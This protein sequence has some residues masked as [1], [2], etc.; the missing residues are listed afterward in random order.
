MTKEDG[1]ALITFEPSSTKFEFLMEGEDEGEN[2]GS[3]SDGTFEEVSLERNEL[4][5]K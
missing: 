5:V 1:I 2:E 4:N 3:E